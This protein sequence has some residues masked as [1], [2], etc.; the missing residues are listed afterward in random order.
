MNILADCL[1]QLL[2][3]SLRHLRQRVEEKEAQI[4]MLLHMK[5]NEVTLQIFINFQLLYLLH[6]VYNLGIH[7]NV[8]A[9]S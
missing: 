4:N 9:I 1:T 5:A 2:Q 7:C 3:S 8:N 6:N